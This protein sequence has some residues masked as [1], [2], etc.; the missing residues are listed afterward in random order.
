MPHIDPNHRYL[1]ELYHVENFYMR[2]IIHVIHEYNEL[3][4]LSQI[5]ILMDW[6]NNV[7]F[8]Q[9]DKID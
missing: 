3:D 8:D 7:I 1:K 4:V 6:K 5:D 2:F 9:L